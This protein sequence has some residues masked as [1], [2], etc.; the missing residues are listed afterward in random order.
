MKLVRIARKCA[1]FFV[2][3]TAAMRATRKSVAGQIWR[4]GRG[5]RTAGLAGS[6]TLTIIRCWLWVA[7]P[8]RST[9]LGGS[10]E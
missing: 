9:V 5:L 8:G 4:A 7:V 6:G 1:Q 2:V 3:D 10:S